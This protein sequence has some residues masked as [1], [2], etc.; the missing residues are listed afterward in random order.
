KLEGLVY[1]D[2]SFARPSAKK[3]IMGDGWFLYKLDVDK[4]VGIHATQKKEIHLFIGAY[5][6][7]I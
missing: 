6:L 1:G 4:N 5:L 7:I 2:F 3:P